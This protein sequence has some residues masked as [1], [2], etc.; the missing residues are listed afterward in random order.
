MTDERDAVTRFL[1][2]LER[3]QQRI[4]N[5]A[6]ADLSPA[7]SRT[8]VKQY[9]D[10][11]QASSSSDGAPLLD[12]SMRAGGARRSQSFAASYVYCWCDAQDN[13][14]YVGKGYGNR[15]WAE[16]GHDHAL[17]YANH[18]LGGQYSVHVLC[19]QLTDDKAFEIEEAL[20][21][22]FGNAFTNWVN[23]CLDEHLPLSVLE[24]R[25]SDA[26]GR[27]N[28][29]QLRAELQ[30]IIKEHPAGDKRIEQLRTFISEL[31]GLEHANEERERS[32]AM[33]FAH[34]SLLHR[35]RLEIKE[36]RMNAV[37]GEAVSRLV[38]ELWK[39]RRYKEVVAAVDGFRESHPGHFVDTP[40]GI[41]MSSRDKALVAKRQDAANRLE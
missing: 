20:I 9:A 25:S 26:R 4:T 35:M 1:A 24:T 22:L 8:I 2:I 21:R 18:F 15:A 31:R 34:I 14:F 41:Q 36:P 19:D 38:S 40:G 7:Y 37:L 30:K 12:F 16:D 39:L 32:D 3:E 33:E 23:S 6:I 29:G 28:Q 27:R 11:L 17:R 13:V 10:A 5:G